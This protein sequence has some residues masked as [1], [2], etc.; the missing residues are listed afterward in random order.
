MIPRVRFALG[1]VV[2][3]L[4]AS[5]GASFADRASADFYVQRGEK[6]LREKDWATATEQLQK[7]IEEDER[8]VQAHG[9]LGE[10]LLGAGDRA[11]GLAALRKAVAIAEDTKPLPPGWVAPLARFRKRLAEI[12]TAGVALDRLVDKYVSD[13]LSFGERW[14]AK[15]FE[16]VSVAV[17]EL[18][19]LRPGDPRV[20]TLG[21]KVEKAEAA[22]W[23]PLFNGKDKTGWLWLDAREWFVASGSLVGD[24]EQKAMIA[25]SKESYAGDFDLRAEVRIVKRYGPGASFGL[26]G[27]FKGDADH[28]S[29]GILGEHLLYEEVT[30]PRVVDKKLE[31]KPGAATPPF[32]PE[33]WNVYELRFRGEEIV[34]AV[35]GTVLG[36]YPRPPAR[37]RGEV[38]IRIQHVIAHFR[39]IEVRPR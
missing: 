2:S 17:K 19:R 20:K 28:A 9:A 4:I 24:V 14:A 5:A 12:D 31:V 1:L 6:A 38:G 7:A 27:A 15:D 30:G 13:L 18:R 16:T 11:A 34:V 26:L 3:L 33:Q 37:D 25:K 35:N 39:R 10:A 32:D 8:H 36:K 23:V 22:S 21:A 29:L